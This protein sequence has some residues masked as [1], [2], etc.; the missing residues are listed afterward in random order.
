MKEKIFHYI[1]ESESL[2]IELETELCKWPAISPD[3]GGEGELD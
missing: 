1:D 2:A 3:S